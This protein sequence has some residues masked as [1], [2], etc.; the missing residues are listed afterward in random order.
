MSRCHILCHYSSSWRLMEFHRVQCLDYFYWL[1]L[2]KIGQSHLIV[3]QTWES[4]N[5]LKKKKYM[6]AGK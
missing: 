6:N 3:I 1:D 2:G 5:I 4:T